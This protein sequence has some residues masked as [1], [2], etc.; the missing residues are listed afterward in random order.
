MCYVGA[1][2]VPT[3]PVSTDASWVKTMKAEALNTL[4][5]ARIL[6]DCAH[7]SCMVDNKHTASAGLVVLQDAVELF[8][9]AYLIEKGV[10]ERSS[11]EGLSFD[12]LIA[13]LKKLGV[14]V[15][16]SGT[17]KAMNK[18]RVIVKHYGQLA[19]P[20]TVRQ[21]FEA[22]QAAVDDLMQQAFGKSANEIL[23]YE[24]IKNESV[25]RHL[26][27]ASSAIEARRFFEALVEIRKVIFIEIEQEYCIAGWKDTP[28]NASGARLLLLAHGGFKAP[29]HCRCKEWIEENV[30]DPFDFIRLDH[31]RLRIDLLEWGVSTQDFWNL[32]RLTPAVF[33]ES[34][35]SQWLIKEDVPHLVN[36]GTEA[37]ARYCLDRAYALLLKKQG[38]ADLSRYLSH[39]GIGRLRVRL[40]SDQPLYEKAAIDSCIVDTLHKGQDYSVDGFVPGLSEPT[41]F[42]KILDWK[43]PELKGAY[44]GY[45]VYNEATCDLIDLRGQS[46]EE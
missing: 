45:I 4:V 46:E 40:K 41:K 20:T 44:S 27:N 39:E 12:E 15:I 23:L 38:H 11:L 19:E 3:G 32:W 34:K 24:I 28:R 16:K 26:E 36:A 13:K 35:D 7:S 17:I 22:A 1:S 31:D 2:P 42:A 14:R 30:K 25:R 6:L 29:W 9:Y 43:P 10:D 5:T 33:R 37:N 8:L 21:Y 18:Q